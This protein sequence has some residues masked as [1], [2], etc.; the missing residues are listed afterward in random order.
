[1]QMKAQHAHLSDCACCSLIV[2]P[3][4]SSRTSARRPESLQRPRPSLSWPLGTVMETAKLACKVNLRSALRPSRIGPWEPYS[5]RNQGSSFTVW[6]LCQPEGLI[7]CT[8][9]NQTNSTSF[10]AHRRTDCPERLGID[11]LLSPLNSRC[12]RGFDS[13]R[14]EHNFVLQKKCCIVDYFILYQ[15]FWVFGNIPL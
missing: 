11:S 2:S 13:G 7:S 5:Y 9:E 6:L 4:A 8:N 3:D 14:E 15:T 1:M 10:K 12:G